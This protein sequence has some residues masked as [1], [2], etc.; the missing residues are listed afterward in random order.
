MTVTD[1]WY[2]RDGE[3]PTRRHGRGKRYRVTV[4]GHPSRAFHGKREAQAWERELFRRR[5]V[6]VGSGITVGELVTTWLD[7]KEGLS[8]KGVEACRNAAAHVRERWEDEV[9]ATVEEHE[10][11]AWLAG[12][13][14]E[15]GPKAKRRME[16]ASPSVRH[17]ALQCIRGA[18]A[19]AVKSEEIG[20]NPAEGVTTLPER[21]RDA[22]FLTVTEL[23]ALA[24]AAGGSWVPMV[25]FLGTTGVR[26]G[27]CCRLNV[28]D[29]MEVRTGAWRAR[30]RMAKGRKS[31]DV[32]VTKDVVTMLD[33]DRAA[34]EP[35]FVTPRG[36]RV[37]KDNWR[38]RVFSPAKKAA[39]LAGMTPHDLRHTAASLMILSGATVKDVQMALGHA[40]PTVTLRTYAHWW[41]R[42]LDDVAARMS[43]LLHE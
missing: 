31:R 5:P 34:A 3:T 42:G 21:P 4:E 37:L 35:L 12:L 29:V 24:A 14:V 9:A 33:L 39:G 7:G 17:K 16:P 43:G 36:R 38:A 8:P 11:Q 27:E 28:G 20:K 25:M 23:R 19:I 10:I 15:R 2:A 40:D 41:D 1:L 26:I 18:L 6:T 30:V 32:P 13:T 22:I